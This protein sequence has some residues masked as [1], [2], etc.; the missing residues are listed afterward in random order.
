M[1]D[2]SGMISK[3]THS[4]IYKISHLHI[5]T[6]TQSPIYTFSHLHIP[7]LGFLS[8]FKILSKKMSKTIIQHRQKFG[9]FDCVEQLL[10]LPKMDPKTVQKVL[11]Q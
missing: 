10:D 3:F 8:H 11:E 9:S 1:I 5:L 4:H 7:P 2:I 6:F